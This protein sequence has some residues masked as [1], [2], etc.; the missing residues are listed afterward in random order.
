MNLRHVALTC[1]SEENADKFYKTLLGLKK[2]GPKILPSSLSKA[3]FNIDADLMIVNYINESLHFEIFIHSHH[4]SNNSRI[5]HVCI[6]VNDFP[7][8]LQ[9]CRRLNV[10]FVQ[11]P[12]GES[13]IT[14]VSDDDGNLYEMKQ[15]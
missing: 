10:R 3:I 13:M 7:E 5:D 8:F 11:I 15:E 6:E 1:S 4:Q 2:S 9:Q 12:K 14:F